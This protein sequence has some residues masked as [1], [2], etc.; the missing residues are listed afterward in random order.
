MWFFQTLFLY[1]VL[2][3]K[4]IPLISQKWVDSLV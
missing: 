2:D 3:A 4:T 1:V